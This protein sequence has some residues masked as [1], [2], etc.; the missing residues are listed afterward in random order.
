MRHEA[1]KRIIAGCPLVPEK[2][3]WTWLAVSSHLPVQYH[4][5]MSSDWKSR[6]KLYKASFKIFWQANMEHFCRHC[7]ASASSGDRY[8]PL[9]PGLPSQHF[10][11]AL[12]KDGIPP[13]HQRQPKALTTGN[14]IMGGREKGS[15]EILSQS[16]SIWMCPGFP[17]ARWSSVTG[18]L[19]TC[20]INT[21][22]ALVALPAPRSSTA[23]ALGSWWSRLRQSVCGAKHSK[24][25][26]R[27][28]PRADRERGM[29]GL[30]L[31]SLFLL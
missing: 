11:G 28:Q 25:F 13:L 24:M 23:S 18:I 12:R 6:I 17:S 16:Q 3:I 9:S 29:D 2:L 8:S 27:K 1:I 5:S 22:V 15:Q 14:G 21:V 4:L 26:C 19:C 30:F 31:K 20:A 10:A 7:L